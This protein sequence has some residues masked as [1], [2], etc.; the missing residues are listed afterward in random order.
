MV[1]LKICRLLKTSTVVLLFIVFIV[2]I[3]SFVLNNVD[4]SSSSKQDVYVVGIGSER[5]RQ[6]NNYTI[7]NS[8]FR[9]VKR[10]LMQNGTFENQA[11]HSLGA[12]K[13]V[14][15]QDILIKH[16]AHSTELSD[17]FISVKTTYKYHRQR[18]DL[19]LDTWWILAI[20]QVTT[21]H[22]LVVG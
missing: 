14:T 1:R 21:V 18:L 15:K 3:H 12:S 16:E 13:K 22:Y 17:V 7:N 9:I 19:L 20:D 5:K 11:V 6:Q 8:G 2:F 10:S 4:R